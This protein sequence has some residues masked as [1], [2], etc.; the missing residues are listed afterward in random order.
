MTRLNMRPLILKIVVI[1]LCLTIQNAWGHQ[2]SESFSR[3]QYDG[4]R[5]S[6][7]FTVLESE[8]QRYFDTNGQQDLERTLAA[9][10]V[11]RVTP[12]EESGCERVDVFSP[13][14]ANA[15]YLQF[16]ATWKCVG[17]PTAIHVESFFEWEAEHRHLISVDFDL[18]FSQRLL[19]ADQPVW[20]SAHDDDSEAKAGDSSFV[21]FVTPGIRHIFAGLDHIAFL[22][23]LLLVCSRGKGLFW[24]VTGFT[25]GHSLSL[26]LAVLGIVRPNINA[27]EAAIGLTIFLVIVERASNAMPSA[28]SAAVT[29]A[30]LLL[31]CLVLRWAS[32]YEW[33]ILLLLGMT[34]FSFC[35]LE[36]AHELN[37]HAIFRISI[38]GLFGLIHGFGFAGAFLAIELPTDHL[39]R[40]L[41]GFNIGV[42]I[43]QLII[44]A[45][46]V[47]ASEA[48]R[49][50]YGREQL[51]GDTLAATVG[52][53]G[54]F[55][56][57]NRLFV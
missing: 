18:G 39:I 1:I 20:L 49:I 6:V 13:S 28:R 41:L 42:E 51:V 5:L 43:G 24:A 34:L 54:I 35:Y 32:G 14:K 47:L 55:W 26:A 22:L 2:R 29:T 52:G 23:A 19:N 11:A 4:D 27:I 53:L 45:L 25:I 9:Y 16:V 31:V 21:L 50:A 33:Q 7:L 8:A 15:G 17:S 10:L 36:S 30:L 37:G 12:A 44:L 3:W 56:F 46:L 40:S 38:T 48:R 57:A